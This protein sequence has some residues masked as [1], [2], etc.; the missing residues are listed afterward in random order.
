MIMHLS[1][2]EFTGHGEIT[3]AK[4]TDAGQVNTKIK[5]GEYFASGIRNPGVRQCLDFFTA[6][7]LSSIAY[8]SA[9]QKPR[10]C[11]TTGFLIP[12]CICE[13]QRFSDSV[14]LLGKQTMNLVG[15][16]ESCGADSLIK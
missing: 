3:T 10:H 8:E 7:F 14:R 16:Y 6:D 15:R 2:L 5:F 9:E 11:P 12:L 1:R 4:N 13:P